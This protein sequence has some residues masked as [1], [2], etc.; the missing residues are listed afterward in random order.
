[1]KKKLKIVFAL[2][3]LSLCGIIFFQI[4]WVV[5]AYR[6]NKEKFDTNIDLAM[7]RAINDCK[8]DYL[9]SLRKLIASRLSPPETRLKV[10]T[11]VYQF[12]HSIRFIHIDSISN[13]FHAI[14]D[15]RLIPFPEI[16]QYKKQIGHKATQREVLAQVSFNTP[17][18]MSNILRIFGEYDI[19]T[20]G[21]IGS[22]TPGYSNEPYIPA[23]RI[24]KFDKGL[25]NTIYE[26]KS[27][28]RQSD[29][30]KIASHLAA[31]LEKLNIKAP[32]LLRIAERSMAPQRSN[33]RYSETSEYSYKYHGFRLFLPIVGPELFVKAVIGNAQTAIIKKMVLTLLMSALLIVFTIFCFW[34]IFKTIM[35]QKKLAELKDDFINNM[36]HELKTPIATMTV[37][38][39]GLQKFNALN[40]PEKTQRYLQASRNELMRLNDI[41]SRVLNVAAFGDKEVKLVKER[42][43]IDDL[44]K[45][46]IDTEELKADKKVDI[47][48]ENKSDLVTIDADKLHFRNVLVNLVDNAIKYSNES[49]LI[50]ITC[51]KV[52]SNALFSVKDNG[53]GIPNSHINLVFTKFH[54]VPTG[55]VHNVKGTGLGLN[56]VKYVVEAHGG[57]VMAQSEVNTGSEF[58]IS[59]PIING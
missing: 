45:D 57:N 19:A 16:D 27:N 48:Y 35:R 17:A 33:A 13:L 36:T 7:Q 38:I 37:A 23:D 25:H 3:I 32:F 54:R 11:E 31:E 50:K 6:V 40:D 22:Y 56:Y 55:N 47:T 21:I 43:N 42:I 4:Y 28:Y 15:N 34:Y 18:L 1:M 5:N 49:V 20:H 52:G 12:D 26:L 29:S 44:V 14:R 46:V 59:I 8:K 2:I 39:E 10:D 51:Y 41:V 30:L 24:L 9:D 53:I 58:I